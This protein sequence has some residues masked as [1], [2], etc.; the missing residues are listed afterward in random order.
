MTL[1]MALLLLLFY[2]LGYIAGLARAQL[3]G[4]EMVRRTVPATLVVRLE[5]LAASFAQCNLTIRNEISTPRGVELVIETHNPE[6]G[7][8]VQ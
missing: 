3:I 4:E 8:R 1:G 6:S 7:P 5:D 2:V